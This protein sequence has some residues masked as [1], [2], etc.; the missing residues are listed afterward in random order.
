MKF[1]IVEPCPLKFWH[2]NLVWELMDLNSRLV[3]LRKLQVLYSLLIIYQ[4]LKNRNKKV[5]P[6]KDQQAIVNSGRA[7]VML[8]YVTHS[9]SKQAVHLTA[10]ERLL[11]IPHTDGTESLNRRQFSHRPWPSS[12]DNRS[13]NPF[14]SS[15]IHL[16]LNSAD[17]SRKIV[18]LSKVKK[19]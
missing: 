10:I 7:V 5:F 8:L 13:L 1:L 4:H 19:T 15:K 11:K 12:L 9:P 17:I 18:G 16:P 14:I 2:Q 6:D 3:L